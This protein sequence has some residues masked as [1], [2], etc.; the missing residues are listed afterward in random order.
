MAVTILHL[1]T[2][3]RSYRSIKDSGPH[4]VMEAPF[5]REVF[6]YQKATLMT[7]LDKKFTEVGFLKVALIK[8]RHR[9]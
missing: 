7:Y 3:A 8:S 4:S 5:L 1:T 9:Y 2:L 6:K